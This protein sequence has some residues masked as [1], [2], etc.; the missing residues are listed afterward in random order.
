MNILAIDTST[1]VLGVGVVS[2]DKVIG[3]YMTNVKRNHSTRVLPAIDYLLNDCGV[4]KNEI[5]KIVVANGPGSYTGL[6]IG[7]TIGK[8]LAWTLKVPIVGVSSLKV[9]AANAR[10]FEG[11]ISPVMDARRGNIFTGLYKYKDG[12]LQQVEE[13]KHRSVKEWGD[14]LKDFNKPVM[15]VGDDSLIHN[16]IFSSI[17]NDNAIFAPLTLNVPK[18]GELAL[19][20][21]DL[22]GEDA[23]LFK[24]NYLRLSEAEAKWREKNRDN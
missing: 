8:T 15:F 17:L 21:K 20:G 2:Q 10:Y 5:E 13:D 14:Q 9:M 16:E 4:A 19:L 18:P 24:P 3:E 11:L 22:P 12:K 6:R 7:V 23:H 1:N